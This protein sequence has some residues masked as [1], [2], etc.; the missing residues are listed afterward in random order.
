M[1]QSSTSEINGQL[2]QF[3]LN[4]IVVKRHKPKKV[5][6]EFFTTSD[7]SL[8]LYFVDVVTLNSLLYLHRIDSP[9]GGDARF[10]K[11]AH[12]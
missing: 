4:D 7:F 2:S 11:L 1:S 10:T 9:E 12:A 6:S 5:S 8:H 3:F